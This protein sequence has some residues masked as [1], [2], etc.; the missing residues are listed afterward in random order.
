MITLRKPTSIVLLPLLA[1][2]LLLGGA[3]PAAEAASVTGD[4]IVRSARAQ[5][6][7]PY[8]FGGNGPR[9]FDCSGLVRH[10]LARHGIN[11]VPRASIDQQRWARSITRSQL[12]PGDLVFQSYGSRNGRRGTDH[13]AIFAGNGRVVDSSPSLGGVIERPLNERVV[14]GYGRV[15]GVAQTASSTRSTSAAS[16]WAGGT[17]R[18]EAARIVASTLRLPNRSNP[19]GVTTQRG[20]VGAVYHAGI[21]LPFADGTW[22]PNTPIT[23]GQLVAWLDRGNV[24]RAEAARIVAD[25]KGLRHRSNPFGVTTQRGA[26]GAVY[27]AGIGLPFAD[28]TWRPN[29]TITRSQLQA[30]MRRAG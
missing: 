3:P 16:S 1:F 17:T 25:V 6:G 10:A 28:G 24:S 21:G 4:Q 12:R 8:S 29:A 19:F 18:A 27:H 9:T 2:A 11:G 5:L 15:P 30:W 22:R 7:T 13:V 23:K 26:V 14:T 20:A